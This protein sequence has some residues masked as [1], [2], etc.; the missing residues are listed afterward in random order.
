M[1][2]I[3]TKT[4]KAI[5][6]QKE[7]AIVGSYAEG[8]FGDDIMA[9]IFWKGLSDAD[10]LPVVCNVPSWNPIREYI[11]VEDDLSELLSRVEC[12][13]VGG[14]GL[15][16]LRD[17][18]LP[19]QEPFLFTIRSLNDWKERLAA[20]R[21]FVASIGGNGNMLINREVLRLVHNAEEV[22]LRLKDEVRP[23]QDLV[24][25]KVLYFPDVV[26]S[27]HTLLQSVQD[28]G[29]IFH[30]GFNVTRRMGVAIE[31]FLKVGEV[32]LGTKYVFLQTHPLSSGHDYEY[33]SRRHKYNLLIDATDD[34]LRRLY[35]VQ[36]VYSFKL[37]IGVVALSLG[38]EARFSSRNEKVRSFL[39]D[40]GL[41]RFSL[42]GR[43]GLLLMFLFSW[44]H[45]MVR[46]PWPQVQQ[47]RR[48]S[49]NHL[50]VLISGLKK[51]GL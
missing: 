3:N 49:E 40:T 47:L 25:R 46:S 1:S 35:S 21:I 7:V 18:L 17:S 36:R 5:M 14:G 38:R 9:R 11:R 44:V 20:H 22:T 19:Y 16:L 43:Y 24:H 51:N 8:N 33:R 23:L 39:R 27:S 10:F 48:E 15:L 4:S 50:R 30:V 45:R 31:P 28:S 6:N 12:V 41:S 42:P 32:L 26:F 2:V 37:H 13:V 29:P 34:G